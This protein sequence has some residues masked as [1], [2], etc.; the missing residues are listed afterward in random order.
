[1]RTL[2]ASRVQG[3]ILPIC[4]HIQT[5]CYLVDM[6]KALPCRQGATLYKKPRGLFERSRKL[7]FVHQ[8]SL[9]SLLLVSIFCLL[10][11]KFLKQWKVLHGQNISELR[12]RQLFQSIVDVYLKKCYNR[13]T[14]KSM[15]TFHIITLFPNAFDSY[16]GESI[17][18]RAIEDKK[19]RVRFY[20]PRDF[21]VSKEGKKYQ[22][23]ELTYAERRVDASSVRR[24][25]RNG[26]RGIAGYK[27][28]REGDA[29]IKT[30]SWPA[31][32]LCL[33]VSEEGAEKV[34]PRDKDKPC[35][36]HF[37]LSFGKQFTTLTP[38]K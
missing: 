8:P 4:K 2:T 26:D 7:N 20:N 9:G 31:G 5:R 27:S 38:K 32:N 14:K 16:L 21:A 25:P 24:R 15:T 12:H 1:M 17:L 18:K 30:A 19:I 28:D 13:Y 36:D 33:R 6:H 11:I 37:F 10:I 23:S 34:C 35:K 22:S 29:R 3:A